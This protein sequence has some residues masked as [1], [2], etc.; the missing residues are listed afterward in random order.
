MNSDFVPDTHG[1]GDTSM[2]DVVGML[3]RLS[4][5]GTHAD[6]MKQ[7]TRNM[8]EALRV[9]MAEVFSPPRVT[10]EGRN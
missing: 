2:G 3:M 6:R 5:E 8:N 7:E 1:N 9:D 4:E 10:A